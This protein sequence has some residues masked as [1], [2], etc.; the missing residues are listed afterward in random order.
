MPEVLELLEKPDEE[1]R[2][3][4]KSTRFQEKTKPLNGTANFAR[5]DAYLKIKDANWDLWPEA[6]SALESVVSS[7]QTELPYLYLYTL[8]SPPLYRQVNSCLR[9]DEGLETVAGLVNHIR[10]D[11]KKRSSSNGNFK[12]RVWRGVSI[13]EEAQD[14]YFKVGGSFMWQGFVS[15]SKSKDTVD[16]LFTNPGSIVFEID[17]N[18]GEA[19]GTTYAVELSDISEYPD[20][21]EV[22]IYPYSGYKIIDV[23]MDGK[24]PLVK[25]VTHDTRLLE[26]DER[27]KD[28]GSTNDMVLAAK[29]GNW[30]KLLELAKARPEC[31]N[32]RPPART[33]AA[34]HQAAYWGNTD[35]LKALVQLRADP[36]LSSKDGK[37]AREVAEERGKH[38][39]A[40]YMNSIEESWMENANQIALA[41]KFARWDEMFQLIK[42]YPGCQNLLPNGRT[43]TCIHQGA[44]WGKVDML[45]KLVSGGA[46]MNLRSKDGK[47][48][49]EIAWERDNTEAVEYLENCLG[50]RSHGKSTSAHGSAGGRRKR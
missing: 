1:A 5:S 26:R 38:E 13:D 2:R 18:C 30:E 14:F 48:P 45:H 50:Y 7:G 37:T 35:V 22:L 21:E 3:S 12:G 42:K 36:F 32:I 31:V 8:E 24:S 28:E 27:E 20:E 23:D 29:H 47:T 34:I 4:C 46:D 17:V 25:L 10:S 44:W 11:M 41:S 49:L 43:Y 40:E 16:L 15:T 9:Q 39:A 6:Q 33:Y 19:R